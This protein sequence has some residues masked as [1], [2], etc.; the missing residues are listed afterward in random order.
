[1][2]LKKPLEIVIQEEASVDLDVI[3]DYI[4]LSSLLAAERLHFRIMSRIGDLADFPHIGKPAPDKTLA[5]LGVRYI[6]EGKYHIYY[7]IVGNAVS[8]LHIIHSARSGAALR[9]LFEND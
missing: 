5:D 6:G 8:I 9:R 1:M 2:E 7:E 4:G 3:S